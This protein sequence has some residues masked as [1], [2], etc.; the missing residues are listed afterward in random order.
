MS[1]RHADEVEVVRRDAAPDQFRWRD[2]R[3]QVRDVLAQWTEAVPWWSSAAT[4]A[5]AAGDGAA[6]RSAAPVLTVDDG[7]RE[8]WRVEATSGGGARGVFDLCFDWSAARWLLTT[9]VD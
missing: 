1:R 7:E 5:L 4:A 2:R 8:F 9:V 3:Y 6:G